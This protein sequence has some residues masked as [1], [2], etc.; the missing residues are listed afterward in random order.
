MLKALK[1]VHWEFITSVVLWEAGRKFSFKQNVFDHDYAAFWEL[2]LD[3]LSLKK[4]KS[5]QDGKAEKNHK[6]AF[7]HI[8]NNDCF[9]HFLSALCIYANYSAESL[10]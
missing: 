8:K 1:K 3:K 2:N 7:I 4:T 6:Y 5:L 9:P 10:A